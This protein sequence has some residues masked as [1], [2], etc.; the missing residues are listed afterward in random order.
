VGRSIARGWRN[1]QRLGQCLLIYRAGTLEDL[2][3]GWTD[4]PA[5]GLT[6][7]T[8]AL[9][10]PAPDLV[11][12]LGEA[13]SPAVAEEEHLTGASTGS[14]IRTVDA[15]VP[16]E[17]LGRVIGGLVWEHLAARWNALEGRSAAS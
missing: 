6:S 17:Q 4:A 11:I 9:S 12:L 15:A 8:D 16:A 5:A 10:S 2:P 3:V 13:G 7:V 14:D 1:R